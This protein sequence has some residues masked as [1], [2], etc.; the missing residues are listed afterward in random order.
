[1]DQSVLQQLKTLRDELKLQSHLLG[2]DLKK[3]WEQAE[4]RFEKIESQLEDAIAEVGKFNEE[5]WVGNKQEVDEMIA[6]YS[7]LKNKM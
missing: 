4:S 6:T 3:E 7:A 2:M 5:F 1:M